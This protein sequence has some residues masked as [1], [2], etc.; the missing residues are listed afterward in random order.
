METPTNTS[1]NIV[2]TLVA[3][4]LIGAVA[5]TLANQNKNTQPTNSSL[6]TTANN[7]STT[8]APAQAA[9]VT[10]DGSS[11]SP[12]QITLKAGQTLT[13]KN[14]ASM[15]VVVDSNPHPVHT[16]DPELN[17]GSIAAGQSQTVTLNKTGSFGLHNH[18]NPAQQG[19]VTI[20]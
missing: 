8:P 4:V 1:R 16:D 10:Y 15:A 12:A 17:V 2:L 14:T 19:Q 6:T 13:F 9:V 5:I 18:I 11:F 20:Q 7:S 3:V